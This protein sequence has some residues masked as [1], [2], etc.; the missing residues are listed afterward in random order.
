MRSSPTSSRTR[1]REYLRRRRERDRSGQAVAVDPDQLARPGA[2]TP[3]GAGDQSKGFEKRKRSRTFW[4]LAHE[5]WV[6]LRGHRAIVGLG[7][8]TV[9]VAALI[10]LAT[11]YSTKIAI[12]YIL[13]DNPG[14]TGLPEWVP[15]PRDAKTLLI[16]L[17]GVLIGLTVIS[18]S[19]GVWGRWRMTRL[20]K[21]L[22]AE[23]RRRVFDH[24]ANL[25]L[26]R[27]YELKSG[28]VASILRE[29]AGNAANIVF[30][31]I[32]NPWRAV[33][34]LIGTLIVLALVDWTMLIGA[35]LLIPILW[36]SQKT[37]LKRIRPVYRDIRQTRTS[38]DAQATE[39]FGG[40]R[41][42][43]GFGRQRGEASRFMRATHLMA[44][45]EILVWWWSR[46]LEVLWMILIPVAS[47]AVLLYGGWRVIEGELTI[48]DLMAFTAY[49]IMLL[50]PLESLTTSAT[51][52][53]TELAA[54]D[55]TLDLLGESREFAKTPE[56]EGAV[57]APRT[58]EDAGIALD[59][60]LVRGRITLEDLSFTYPRGTEK[61]LDRINLDVEPGTTVALVG[62][63][64]AGKTT[65]CNLVARFYDPTGGQIRLDGTDLKDIDVQTYRRTLGIVEQDVFL[66]DGTIG[67]NIAFARRDA[68][69]ED[70]RAAAA[71]AN[72]AEFIEKTDKGYATLIGERGVRLSG[73]QKQRLAIARALLADPRILILDEATSSLDTESEALI[74]ES[75]E[76]LMKGRTSFVIAHRLST[77]RHA[78]VI[79][80]I[81]HG[82][83][84][85]T[86]SHEELLA[87]DGR[88]AEMLRAQLKEP[89]PSLDRLE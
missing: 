60:A 9:T 12:D 23:L 88:Y 53:Q 16:L 40:M 59:P 61:V 86:G 1:Y 49:L 17:S 22:Q 87:R 46:L 7:V 52:I 51:N 15:G 77:I 32:Y 55:R 44:R 68:T 84:I 58:G 73:G 54:L 81:E 10:G 62:R 39:A 25:P 5:F 35:L 24:T 56:R 2:A 37:W 48:G 13:T 80:V 3:E 19:I 45:Q 41:V 47:S 36:F 50:S 27:V 69:D 28:G 64:G 20:T 89:D 21:L 26:N 83:I 76:E 30:S 74:Q 43:R 85:E 82:R 57:L 66:F 33:V 78:D 8:V 4:T 67:D 11:P 14:P 70:V 71:L 79:V 31:M 42:V 6:L 29:D 63:S 72:A 38:I 75:L 65:L 34:Q 18:T